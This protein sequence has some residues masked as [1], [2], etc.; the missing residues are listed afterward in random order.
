MRRR[1]WLMSL[2]V[3]IAM[4]VVGCQAKKET[5]ENTKETQVSPQIE[6]EIVGET[7]T[8]HVMKPDE[9]FGATA[10]LVEKNGKGLLV[11]T[12]FSKEN[13]N[14]IVSYI[15]ERDSVRNYL[16]FL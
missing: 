2:A 1:K 8:Y 16:Y 6:K 5:K 9:V 10:V 7:F 11:D 15:K 12:Q 3:V 14:A 13:A 4:G